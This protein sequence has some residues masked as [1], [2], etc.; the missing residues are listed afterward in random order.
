[1]IVYAM[2]YSILLYAEDVKLWLSS[3]YGIIKYCEK[4]YSTYTTPN[5]YCVRTIDKEMDS[6]GSMRVTA[7]GDTS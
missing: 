1:M 5:V 2:I 7:I 3:A 6:G 4:T